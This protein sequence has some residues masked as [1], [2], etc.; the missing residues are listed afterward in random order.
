[1]TDTITDLE[2]AVIELV[3]PVVLGLTL[4]GV[5]VAII[6]TMI[7]FIKK[8]KRTSQNTDNAFMP[9]NGTPIPST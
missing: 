1:M 6:L 7:I 8:R 3:V 5:I 2:R 4:A 9:S